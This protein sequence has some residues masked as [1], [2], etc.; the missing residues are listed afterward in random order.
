M[1]NPTVYKCF[2]YFYYIFTYLIRHYPLKLFSLQVSTKIKEIGSQK[3]L[4]CLLTRLVIAAAF[5]LSNLLASRKKLIFISTLLCRH[6]VCFPLELYAGATNKP[7]E[8][9]NAVLRRLVSVSMFVLTFEADNKNM[10]SSIFFNYSGQINDFLQNHII[11][12][13]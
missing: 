3:Q 6:N 4:S 2:C 8:L 10:L 7:Q 11:T 1:Y 13:F 9:D 5:H 12:L